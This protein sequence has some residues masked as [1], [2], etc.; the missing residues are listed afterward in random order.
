MD[1]NAKKY[2][3]YTN[4]Q[5][6]DDIQQSCQIES[7]ANGIT[8]RVTDRERFDGVLHNYNGDVPLQADLN[9]TQVTFDLGV[10]SSSHRSSGRTT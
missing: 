2:S 6:L 7:G 5:W 1:P 4:Q 8:F 3:Q 9:G 10:P